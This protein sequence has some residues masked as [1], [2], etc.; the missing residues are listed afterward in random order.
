[1]MAATDIRLQM[2]YGLYL[3]SALMVLIWGVLLGSIAGRTTLDSSLLVTPLV[4]LNLII[5]TFYFMAALVLFER[6]EGAIAALAM[7]PLRELEYLLSK[8]VTLALLAAGETL[9]IVA[10]LFGRGMHWPALIAGTMML[11]IL[12]ALA[13]MMTVARFDS[14]SRFLMPSVVIVLV[15]ILPLLAHFGF[16]PQGAAALHPATSSMILIS[17]ASGT[18]YSLASILAALIAA[19]VWC[20]VMLLWSRRALRRLI[21]RSV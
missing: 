13:G 18:E 15:L 11:G 8:A 6:G 16:I 7:T 19:P 4:V 10:L 3:V 17:H 21:V 2:R 9:L 1:M 14:L 5:T 20:I 12:Y